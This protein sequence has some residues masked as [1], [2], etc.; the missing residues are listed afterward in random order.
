M[1]GLLT[2]LAVPAWA[3]GLGQIE[4]KSRGGEPLLAE[5]PIVSSDPQEL[6]G[7]Q[8]Q[9]AS[10]D[11]YSR[12]GLP[13][14][15]A[16]ASDLRFDLIV[17]AA[18]KPR[19]RITSREP[20][21]EPVV[22]FLVQVD[23]GQGKLVREYS[24]LVDT[25]RTVQAPLQPP[26]D[27]PVAAPGNT[28]IQAPVSDPVAAADDE[29]PE[30]ADPAQDPAEPVQADT[31][32]AA[33]PTPAEPERQPLPPVLPDEDALRQVEYGSAATAA[34]AGQSIAAGSDYRIQ[35]GDTLSA[36]ADSL[37]LSASRNQ[38]MV[39]LLRANPQAFID[40]NINRIKAGAQLSMP[41][42]DSA[43]AVDDREANAL[44]RQHVQAWRSEQAPLAQPAVV[45][46]APAAAAAAAAASAAQPAAAAPTG[47][48]LEIAPPSA[49]SAQRTGSTSGMTAGGG[50]DM[51][52]QD[53]QDAQETLAARTAE[54][55]EL[56]ARVA[57]L[58][59]L[60]QDQQRLIQMKDNELAAA[61]QRTAEAAPAAG[62]PIW[63]WVVP[64]LLL[65]AIV[66]LLLTRRR[67]PAAP[68]TVTRASPSWD[69][70][71]AAAAPEPVPAAAADAEPPTVAA[72]DFEPVSQPAWQA[73][74]LA[75]AYAQPATDAAPIHDPR[76]D[77]AHA[78]I[79][80]GDLHGARNYLNDVM[81]NADPAAQAEAAR[82][83]RDLT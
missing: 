1:A 20:V 76:L 4:V 74:G 82:L 16:L 47:A 21:Q 28:I 58:E 40:G 26:I 19:I 38:I 44:V 10:P 6:Y 34:P 30:T 71:Q 8:A 65:A 45:A 50:G 59:Q 11:T 39:A 78:C 29:A 43:A 61:Q 80:Q 33:T 14:S 60:Q 72:A 83:L 73:R 22:Q 42:A 53:L 63:L 75:A 62:V 12:I 77:K 18:G 2:L 31:S 13:Y 69:A 15:Q 17:D 68:E 48:R 67:K 5:I 81:A 3:L 52:R 23:W 51:L 56:K 41:T 37:G 64:V 7:L 54:V 46:G 70:G 49:S 9:L 36:I 66:G 32:V 79:D 24:A 35:R 57:E 25:P 27:A 55:D